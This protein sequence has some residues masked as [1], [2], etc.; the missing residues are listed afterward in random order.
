[1]TATRSPGDAAKAALRADAR[2]RRTAIKPP[3]HAAHSAIIAERA[4]AIIDKLKPSVVAVYRAINGEV[5]PDAIVDRAIERGMVVVLPAVKDATTLIFRRYRPG[6]PMAAGGFGTLAPAP[7][8]PE[9]DPDLVISPMVGF[10]RS[11]TRLGHGRGYYDRGMWRLHMKGLKPVLVGLAFS[12]QEVP[13]IPAD[14]HDVRMDWIVTEK[15]TL[16]L[17]HIG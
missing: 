2:A 13:T 5:V 15:E 4:I 1:M 8:A 3:V 17:T 14:P 11:G 9:I 12:V 6:E 10:D 16:D 7:G